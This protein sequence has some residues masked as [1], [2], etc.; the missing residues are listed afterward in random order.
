MEATGKVL[1]TSQGKNKK[2]VFAVIAGFVLV[3]V[4]LLARKFIVS[5][6]NLA[7][8]LA[9][10]VCVVASILIIAVSSNNIGSYITV[11]ENRIEGVTKGTARAAGWHFT[12]GFHDIQSIGIDGNELT[13]I[14][15]DG[16]LTCMLLGGGDEIR[17]AIESKLPER[18][19][20]ENE[21]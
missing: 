5:Y 1:A 17:R 6:N 7:A 12:I 19:S 3:V 8:N 11:Y 21:E 10:L 13:I 14:T 20:E 9:C 18:K 4:G 15:E 2:L 16:K